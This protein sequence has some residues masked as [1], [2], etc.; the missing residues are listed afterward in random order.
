MK[1]GP[2]RGANAQ[3][4]L[5]KAMVILA[6]ALLA[7]CAGN[8]RRPVVG[9]VGPAPGCQSEPSTSSGSL[10]VFSEREPV[11]NPTIPDASDSLSGDSGFTMEYSGYKILSSSGSV[12]K[13]VSN[14]DGQTVVRP[15]QVELPAGSYLVEAEA[16]KYGE[17][18][19]PVVIAEGQ[20]TVLNLGDSDY[21][22]R[23]ARPNVTNA[24]CFPDGRMIGWRADE[25]GSSTR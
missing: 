3:G 13:F 11:A 4:A 7:G 17:V 23:N 20:S 15:S 18:T 25:Q 14:N 16:E 21:W 10:I 2:C 24:V 8:Q 1:D 9:I 6:A 19:V 5:L 22:L 12:V